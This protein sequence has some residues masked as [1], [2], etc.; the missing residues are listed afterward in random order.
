M[1]SD[2][3]NVSLWD[4]LELNAKSFIEAISEMRRI[5]T[6]LE[7]LPIQDPNELVGISTR[8]S[9]LPTAE[10]IAFAVAQVGA[11]SAWVA[12][13]RFKQEMEGAADLT[14]PHILRRVQD[15]ELRF[16]DHLDFIRL[17]VIHDD[18]VGLMSGADAL[19]GE[20]CATKF[21]SLWYDCEEAAKC[22]CLGR[23]TACVFH[24]MRMLEGAIRA[25]AR[26]L[27][28]PDPL[29]SN[30]RN[31]G[32]ML[33]S[34]KEKVDNLYPAK[35]RLAGSEGAYL[36]GVYVSLDAIKNPWRN[37]TMHVENVYTEEE[38]RH[39][40]TCSA[41]LIQKMSEGFDENGVAGSDPFLLP[42]H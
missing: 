15:I 22:L 8:Q 32:A 38:A 31:W 7:S 21:P 41:L 9:L 14:G 5:A 2:P 23:A 37:A 25:L 17:F 3:Q 1:H 40:L 27:D 34:I 35:G 39:I 28:I 12:A 4:M 19:L 33:R 11:K 10:K 29:T 18:K 36:D 24:S 42:D 13:D 6:V 26:R 16:A 20:D 30:E